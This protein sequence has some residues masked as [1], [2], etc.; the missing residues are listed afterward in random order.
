TAIR[1]ARA[2]RMDEIMQTVGASMLGMTVSCARCHNHKFDP[3]TIKDYYSLTAVFQGVE[4]GG[5]YPEYAAEHPRKQR[6]DELYKSMWKKR[7]ILRKDGKVWVENWGAYQEL[8]FPPQVAQ[9]VRVVIDSGWGRFDEIEFLG[10]PTKTNTILSQAADGTTVVEG[11]NQVN[12]G[13][14]VQNVIDGQYGTMGWSVKG[15]KGRKMRPYA[16]FTFSQPQEIGRLRLSNNREYYYDTDYLEAKG[17]KHFPEYRV[18]VLDESGKW[19]TIA[20]SKMALQ[21]LGPPRKAALEGVQETIA[22]LMEEGPRTSFVGRWVRPVVTHVLHRGSPESPRD[23]VMPSGFEF[24][25]GDLGLNRKTSGQQRRLEFAEWLTRPEHPLTARVMV[26]RVWHHI[27]G[28]GIVATTADFGVAGA[29]PSHPELLDWLTAEWV[30]PEQVKRTPWSMKDL[31]RQILFTDAFRQSSAPR[32]DGL[33]ADSAARA[34]WRFPPRRMEAEVIRDGILQASGKL[35]LRLGGRSYRI[36]NVKKTY[37]QWEVVDNHGEDTWRRMLYQERMRRV[38]DRIFTAFD[39]PDCGQ[40]RDKRPVST[41][42]LQALNLMNSPFAIE[43]S[44]F[45]AARAERKAGADEG[46][47]VDLAFELLLGRMPDADERSASIAVMKESGLDVVCRSII[48]ANEF[49]FIP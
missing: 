40:V 24:L 44:A 35:D 10:G 14:P 31:M 2:D 1:Q 12:A 16:A 21:Q 32:E 8:H 42:P 49:A 11:D 37:A 46:A 22:L 19:K 26:N 20:G 13:S 17:P 47:A 18:E 6:A 36:H 34:L 33:G 23:E 5:R 28:T 38:D 48:N 9:K 41:T 3:I 30:H 4:F 43:Q 7:S 45:V 15:I 39:F 27:F 25:E 29:P